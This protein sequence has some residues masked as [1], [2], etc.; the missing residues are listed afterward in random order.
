MREGE[1]QQVD[2]PNSVYESPTTRFVGSFIGNP[3]MNFVEGRISRNGD[4]VTVVVGEYEFAPHAAVQPL[5]RNLSGDRVVLGIRAENME[6]LTEPVADSVPVVV[7][8][9]EPL[10]SQN[11]LT[12]HLAGHRFKVSTH[13]TFPAVAD[14]Q[15][16]VRL[17]ADQIRWIDPSSEQVLYA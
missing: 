1:I 12:V 13:P 11:L 9:V 14:T 7:Q 16:F 17:P 3:P 4:G 5:I 10:G 15:L 2:A 6:M 8:V